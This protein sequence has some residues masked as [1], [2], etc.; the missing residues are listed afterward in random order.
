[1][2]SPWYDSISGSYE[3]S[4]RNKE[5]RKIIQSFVSLLSEIST[6]EL[7]IRKVTVGTSCLHSGDESNHLQHKIINI[8]NHFWLKK[9]FSGVDGINALNLDHQIA[10][11]SK[12]MPMKCKP[13]PILMDITVKR[14]FSNELFSRIGNGLV[15]PKT[16]DHPLFLVP[17]IVDYTVVFGWPKLSH[18]A[19]E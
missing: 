16:N 4:K 2:T 15:T 17:K 10:E 8:P 12:S 14:S 13:V 5:M 7:P 1:M 11:K 19:P 9:D 3:A 6:P 18:L